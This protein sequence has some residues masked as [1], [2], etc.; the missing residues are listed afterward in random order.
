MATK[1]TMKMKRVDAEQP[2]TETAGAEEEQSASKLV[3]R[4]PVKTGTGVVV[5][6]GDEDKVSQP[7]SSEETQPQIDLN[8]GVVSVSPPNAL[9]EEMEEVSYETWL[10]EQNVDVA[11]DDP[12]VAANPNQLIQAIIGKSKDVAQKVLD[13]MKEDRQ[14]SDFRFIPIGMPMTME[15]NPGRVQVLTD[16]G[17]RVI[18]VEIS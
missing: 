10:A 3:V 12:S 6:S 5:M 4:Q 17:G 1:K 2:S 15:L 16:A 7:E 18:S 9:E 8:R 14:I 11:S 13:K